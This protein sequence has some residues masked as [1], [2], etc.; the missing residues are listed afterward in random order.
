MAVL[1]AKLPKTFSAN[2][3]KRACQ[4]SLKTIDS[5]LLLHCRG[6]I[7]N[8]VDLIFQTTNG[9][10]RLIHPLRFGYQIIED[11]KKG[12]DEVKLI[13]QGKLKA[14]QAEELYNEL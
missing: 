11:I 8:N 9:K 13:E 7:E 6:N 12:L 4:M 14:R 10:Y 2:E 5:F 1:T 3:I